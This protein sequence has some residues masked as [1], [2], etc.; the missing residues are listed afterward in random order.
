MLTDM[1]SLPRHPVCR[2]RAPM[3]AAHV[4]QSI[5]H[6]HQEG[7]MDQ[8]EPAQP[9]APEPDENDDTEGQAFRW[10]I[11]DDPKSGK[12]LKAGWTP[13]EPQPGRSSRT[14]TSTDSKGSGSR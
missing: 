1:L 7:T 4:A 14:R 2:A 9:D 8:Q 3:V 5:P 11:V 6:R 12:R 10:Q 13:D